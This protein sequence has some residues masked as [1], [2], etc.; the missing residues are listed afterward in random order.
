MQHVAI[1]E[2]RREPVSVPVR[3]LQASVPFQEPSMSQKDFR[4]GQND[5]RTNVPVPPPQ[6]FKSYEA[7][8]D[9]SYGRNSYTPPPA[10]KQNGK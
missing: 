7:K 6:T 8:V 9:Y 5:A 2:I 1:R 3:V 4:A 10:P